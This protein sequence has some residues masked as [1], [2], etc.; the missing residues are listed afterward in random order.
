[1]RISL[2][3]FNG[4]IIF[5]IN[6]RPRPDPSPCPCLNGGICTTTTHSP[7]LSCT[8]LDSYS[9]QTCENYVSTKERIIDTSVGGAGWIV[10]PIVFILLTLMAAAA[11]IVLKRRNY[12]GK[13]N[14]SSWVG[15]VVSFRQGSNVEFGGS[16]GG[17][18][19]FFVFLLGCIFKMFLCRTHH[20]HHQKARILV[21]QC[22]TKQ[23][24]VR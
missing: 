8:C 19:R 21:I 1:M 6:F 15:G 10:A 2:K 18:V 20:L 14:M 9:G 7:E 12:F 23:G 4:K 24:V 16:G 3:W 17:Q 5:F 11:Y 22:M 13:S